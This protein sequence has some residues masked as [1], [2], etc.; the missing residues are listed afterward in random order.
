MGRDIYTYIAI[1]RKVPGIVEFLTKVPLD[2]QVVRVA[3]A[4]ALGLFLGL[5]REWSHKPAGIRTFTLISLL[6]AVFTILERD[7]LLLLG[8]LLVIVQGTMLGV[9]GLI[10]DDEEDV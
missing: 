5:E 6:G 3:L 10:A 4:A 2:S 1:V 9:K 8:G 7:V